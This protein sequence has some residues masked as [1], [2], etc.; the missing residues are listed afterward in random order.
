MRGTEQSILL[1]VATLHTC[2]HLA[3]STLA[4]KLCTFLYGAAPGKQPQC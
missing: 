1:P 2:K 3:G 4:L